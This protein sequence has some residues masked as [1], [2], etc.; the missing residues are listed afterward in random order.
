MSEFSKLKANAPA[1]LGA[2]VEAVTHLSTL[3]EAQILELVSTGKIQDLFPFR[4]NHTAE[5]PVDTVDESEL[6]EASAMPLSG[7]RRAALLEASMPAR[8]SP[9]VKPAATPAR[10]TGA[11]RRTVKK[12]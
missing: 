3:G 6:T 11:A 10:R 4:P 5:L 12:T 8:S 9:S 2:V 1:T 7:E